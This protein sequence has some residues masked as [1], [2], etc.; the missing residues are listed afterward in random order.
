MN[1]RTQKVIGQ[2]LLAIGLTLMVGGIASFLFSNIELRFF[3]YQVLGY[4]ERLYWVI[5]NFI[6]AAAGVV[7]LKFSRIARV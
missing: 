4:Q 6:I 3:D 1:R 5:I 7:F 2:V